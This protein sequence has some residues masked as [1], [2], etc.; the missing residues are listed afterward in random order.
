MN[1]HRLRAYFELLIATA[2]WGFATPV[3]KFTLAGLSPLLFLTYRFGISSIVAVIL[4]AK[5]GI[6]IIKNPGL[7]FFLVIYGLLTST[8][9][10]G[11]L[12]LG[13]D[14]TTAIDGTLIAST[15][16]IFITIAGSIFLNEHVTKREK[17]GI[18]IAFLGTL[19]TVIEP[20]LKFNDGHGA[21]TGNILIILSV[22]V[23]ALVAIM[24]KKLLRDGVSPLSIS[25]YSFIVGFVS[26]LPLA[27][28][29]YSPTG[30]LTMF[31]A[32]PAP[33]LLG[34][35]FMALISG[36][37]AYWLS[38]KA[39]KTIEVSEASLFGYLYPVFATPL[40]V[41]WLKETITTPF[42][43]GAVVITIGVLIAEVKKSRK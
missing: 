41:I 34:L 26:I 25:N 43:I 20:I 36:N 33:Y 37:L 31:L 22:I 19:I 32:I 23:G 24:T 10:L 9:G 11:L 15:G 4:E 21:L 6:K 35:L 30:L 29:S 12:F 1:P 7:L 40:A 28:S 27:L 5:N 17:I 2:V 14:K 3:I 18:T 39:Q 16:P 42:I 38:N 8:I 13:L